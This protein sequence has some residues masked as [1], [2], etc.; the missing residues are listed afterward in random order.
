MVKGQK[1]QRNRSEHHKDLIFGLVTSILLHSIL[2]LPGAQYWLRAFGPERQQE[3]D[4][5]IPI[6]FFEVSP[7]E[8]K[9]PPETSHRA[10]NNSVAGGEAK[11]DQ[12]VSIARSVPAAAPTAKS[13]PPKPRQPVAASPPNLS[14][15]KPQPEPPK[16]AATPP[17]PTQL[18][19]EQQKIVAALRAT[20]PKPEPPQTVAAPTITQPK[21]K[22]QSPK[23]A[24]APTTTQPKP[25]T[26]QE[27]LRPREFTSEQMKP[28]VTPR[29]PSQAQQSSNSGAASRLGGPVSLSSRNLG[30]DSL[31]ALPNSNRSNRGTPGV[32]ARQD[33]DLGFYLKQLQQQVRQQWMPGL[34]QSSWQTVIYFSVNRS[35]QVSNLQ[36][37]RTSGH[38]ATDE[39]AL[40]AVKRA[41]P[42]APLPTA[43]TKDYINIRFTFNINAYGELELRGGR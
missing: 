1:F 8:K 4:Q 32:D 25:S 5:P 14:L 6:E 11:R 2:F 39:A 30:G 13:F 28:K 38:S 37:A 42:F 21:P 34:T 29:K 10:A 35:G 27:N 26:R 17:A 7:E 23:T 15:Q 43:Y 36:I 12:P 31:A 18:K 20:Q 33:V 9:P 16:S 3:L 24:A 22:P 41:A 40:S 19:P